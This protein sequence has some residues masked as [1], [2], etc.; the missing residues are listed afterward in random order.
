MDEREII[1]K[2]DDGWLSFSFSEK[3]EPFYDIELRLFIGD[4]PKWLSI[5]SDKRWHT[6]DVERRTKNV[7]KANGI[8][9]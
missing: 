8:T 1:I 3:C 7:L 5:L 6:E 2:C 4:L 9:I